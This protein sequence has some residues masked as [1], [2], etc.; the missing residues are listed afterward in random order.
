MTNLLLTDRIRYVGLGDRLD[1]LGVAK[2]MSKEGRVKILQPNGWFRQLEELTELFDLNCVYY[3]GK[4]VDYETYRVH[5]PD[6]DHKFWSV[7]DYPRLSVD[8]DLELPEKFVTVQFDGTHGH[9]RIRNPNKILS[10]WRE[11]G[12][13][14]IHVGGKAN[15]DR[16]APKAGNLKN[17][18]YAM[19]KSHGH[20]GVDSGMMHLAKF[21]MDADKICVYTVMERKTS[22]VHTLERKGA[23]V[24]TY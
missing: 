1:A 6:G 8:L 10:E 14:I 21:S 18:A 9:N 22:F 4:P 5:D 7:R 16:F 15:D 19:S 24:L 23:Q 12:Y 20:I 17:I 13:E 2:I 11:R 3:H